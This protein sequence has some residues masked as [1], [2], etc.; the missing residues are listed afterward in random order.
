MFASNYCYKNASFGCYQHVKEKTCFIFSKKCFV[1]IVYVWNGTAQGTSLSCHELKMMKIVIFKVFCCK[2]EFLF[3]YVKA[4]GVFL[5][6]IFKYSFMY[7]VSVFNTY[8]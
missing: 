1:I 5:I 2:K 3:S 8:L 4:D 6:L 7:L